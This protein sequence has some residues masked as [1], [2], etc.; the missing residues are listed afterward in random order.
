MYKKL[1]SAILTVVMVVSMGMTAFASDSLIR[2]KTELGKEEVFKWG[3]KELKVKFDVSQLSHEDL[4]R[5]KEYM[6]LNKIDSARELIGKSVY[7]AE[8]SV[9][10]KRQP[11]EIHLNA[12]KISDGFHSDSMEEYMLVDF[13]KGGTMEYIAVLKIKVNVKGGKIAE[14]SSTSFDVKSMPSY[15]S[16]SNIRIPTYV[17]SDKMHAGM[18]VNYDVTKTI[19]VPIIP[20]F[21]LAGTWTVNEVNELKYYIN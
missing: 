21:P 17:S 20:E 7:S 4:L 8:R 11:I 2:L 13:G 1:L 18:T 16:I 5:I 19:E 14:V 12:N 9:L 15:G 3:E 10:K 6:D